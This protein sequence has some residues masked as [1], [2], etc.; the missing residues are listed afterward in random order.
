MTREEFKEKAK[1]S[2]DDIFAK[3]DE[4][5]VKKNKAQEDVKQKYEQRKAELSAKRADLQMKYQELST[6]SEG[7]WEEAKK[8]F[9]KSLDSLKDGF[10]KLAS[11]FR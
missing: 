11:I 3:L 2:I 6:V 7:K 4:L 1:N 9:Y 10:S 5:E 8:D